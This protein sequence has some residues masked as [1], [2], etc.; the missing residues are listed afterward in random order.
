[1]AAALGPAEESGAEPVAGSDARLEP[2]VTCHACRRAGHRILVC[3]TTTFTPGQDALGANLVIIYM[4][5]WGCEKWG[6]SKSNC[7][8]KSARSSLNGA[9]RVGPG[10]KP[11]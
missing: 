11:L 5:Y 2:E 7:P 3:P 10:T 4:P 8:S 9:A 6:H 1:M